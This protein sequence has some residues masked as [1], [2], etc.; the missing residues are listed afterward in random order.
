[1]VKVEQFGCSSVKG[2]PS[3]LSPLFYKIGKI[4]TVC[5]YALTKAGNPR[6]I[7]GYMISK[8]VILVEEVSLEKIFRLEE[9]LI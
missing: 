7:F 1:M 3:L 4:S 6:K 2:G 9:K 5:C 8:R